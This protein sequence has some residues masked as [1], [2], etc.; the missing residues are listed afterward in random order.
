MTDL[1]PW[2]GK[3]HLGDAVALLRQLPDTCID[4]VVSDPPYAEVSRPYGR[5]TEAAWRELMDAVVVETRRILK[6][7]GSA[8]F[9]LQP[10]SEKVGRMRP[11]LWEFMAYWARE[12]N[13]VQDAWWWNIAAMPTAHCQH[14]VGLLRPSVKAC[15]WFGS[16]G[17][18]RN[19]NGILLSETERTR[20]VKAAQKRPIGDRE[21]YASGHSLNRSTVYSAFDNSGGVTPYNMYP[22]ASAGG[23][24]REGPI[25]HGT[26]TPLTLCDWWVR[27]ISPPGG[28]VLDP[29]MGSGTVALACIQRE[30][31]WLGFEKEPDYVAICEKRIAEALAKHQPA[32]ALEDT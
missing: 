3:V 23:D 21:H 28:V 16:P 17:C 24:V 11:W 13:Q 5:L 9:V 10:N 6:P 8:V 2:L 32:L 14:H 27:Y 22:L 26:D 19:Q 29:F 18:F 4:A 12:W 20:L 30:R 1:S 31:Q 7:T 15:V 25:R